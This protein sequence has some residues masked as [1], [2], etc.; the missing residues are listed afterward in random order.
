MTSTI[1]P[2]IPVAGTLVSSQPIRDNFAAA[3]NDINA[4]QNSSLQFVPYTGASQDTNL[5]SHNIAA[6]NYVLPENGSLISADIT[7]TGT[8][9]IW[10]QLWPICNDQAGGAG[11]TGNPVCSLTLTN[12]S[13]IN[14]FG[15]LA[16]NK[17]PGKVGAPTDTWAFAVDPDRANVEN[18]KLR[19]SGADILHF[20]ADNSQVRVLTNL[21]LDGSV[22]KILQ[23]YNSAGTQIV[24]MARLA[25]V[26]STP[27]Y[28]VIGMSSANLAGVSLQPG[29]AGEAIRI[30]G[31]T[32]EAWFIN[33][34]RIGT[35]AQ[36]GTAK[37][38]VY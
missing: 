3:Y 2:N 20:S 17:W 5:G 16:F 36:G 15:E 24:N 23:S 30:P 25:T 33:R 22:G 6:L 32:A 18:F 31:S 9:Y 10:P 7:G 35:G 1:N 29:T 38:T 14:K 4:L 12:T 19:H 28:M 34:V 27:D 21:V 13:T 11:G 8:S 26:N 37:L